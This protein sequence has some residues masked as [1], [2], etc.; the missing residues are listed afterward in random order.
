MSMAMA[1]VGVI[2]TGYTD[3]YR[4]PI[5]TMLNPNAQGKVRIYERFAAGL[6]GLEGFDYAF[7]ITVLAGDGA[8]GPELLQPT[9]ILLKG[10]GRRIG[11]FATRFPIRPNSIG[12][13]LVRI[14]GVGRTTIDFSGVDMVDGTPVLDIKPWVPAFDLPWDRSDVRI[15]WYSGIDLTAHKE[16]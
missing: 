5:Q 10:T 13:S 4:A 7:L 12:L 2:T 1:P 15:G 3:V 6:K 16:E 9:P 14:E 8:A 11:V